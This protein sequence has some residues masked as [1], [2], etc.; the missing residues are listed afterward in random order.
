MTAF[1]SESVFTQVGQELRP[2]SQR[3]KEIEM[4]AK[5]LRQMQAAA[6]KD[7]Q[8]LSDSRSI[9]VGNVS[10]GF[11]VDQLELIAPIGRL[12]GN[13]GRDTSSFPGLR[14]DQ[15]SDN[16]MRKV[17]RSSKRVGVSSNDCTN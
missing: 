15:P 5:Q 14:D 13:T 8:L 11:D 10:E 9:H 2:M 17:H 16:F 12:L 6:E 1:I 4:E 3:V 7:N